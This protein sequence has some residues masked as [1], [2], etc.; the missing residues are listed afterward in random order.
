MYLT[1]TDLTVPKFAIVVRIGKIVFIVEKNRT[2]PY[3]LQSLG[4][5]VKQVK[6]IIKITPK[7]RF[8]FSDLSAASICAL[9]KKTCET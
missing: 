7:Q 5:R 6:D 3:G 9:L 8:V 2:Y 4:S 1:K